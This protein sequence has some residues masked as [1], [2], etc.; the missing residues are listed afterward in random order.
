M[1]AHIMVGMFHLTLQVVAR[2][3]E[4]VEEALLIRVHLQE[5][6]RRRLVVCAMVAVGLQIQKV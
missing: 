4:V 1:W 2:D 3:M 5:P 6:G